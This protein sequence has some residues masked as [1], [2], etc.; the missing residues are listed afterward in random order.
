MLKWFS[1]GK[2]N[3]LKVEPVQEAHSRR[4][5]S[6]P[7]GLLKKATALKKENKI[8]AA[9]EALR[10]AYKA[11]EKSNLDYSEDVYLRLPMYLQAAGRN[12]EAWAEFNKLIV[13]LPQRYSG[14]V[15][16]MVYSSVYDKMRLFLQRE[17]KHKEAVIQGVLSYVFVA[18]GRYYQA[19]D[20]PGQKQEIEGANSIRN[21]E[22]IEQRM[23]PLLKK[24]GK[25]ARI[26]KV[27][28][29]IEEEFRFFPKVNRSS[30]LENVSKMLL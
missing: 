5:A 9:I 8:E 13:S 15:L 6:T 26:N 27:V 20:L 24:A 18:L 3:E 17:G 23:R 12:D 22:F 2:K 11:I 16:Y 1:K 19:R 14:S 30:L 7:E 10:E 4:F 21:R 28:D 29:A 25:E